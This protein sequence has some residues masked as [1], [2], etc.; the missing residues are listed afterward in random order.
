MCPQTILVA[1]DEPAVRRVLLADLKTGFPACPADEAANGIEAVQLFAERRHSLVVLDVV[2]PRMG[3]IDAARAM[4]DMDPSVAIL[5]ISGYAPDSI[6]LQE[7]ME[8]LAGATR[9]LAKPFGSSEFSRDV[10]ALLGAE[11]AE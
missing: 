4:R 2:M 7:A 1:D 5:F 9:F 10:A 6:G 8:G 11:G 3:G